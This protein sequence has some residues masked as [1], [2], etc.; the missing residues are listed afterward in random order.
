[1]SFN[2]NI[3]QWSHLLNP[4]PLC[5]GWTTQLSNISNINSIFGQGLA[6]DP[7]LAEWQN[8][9]KKYYPDDRPRWVGDILFKLDKIEKLLT[10]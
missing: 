2:C 3:H 7:K 5:S 4:C 9:E 6:N 1:M 10:K 8:N